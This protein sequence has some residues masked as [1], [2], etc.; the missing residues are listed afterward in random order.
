[1]RVLIVDD[2]PGVRQ[3]VAMTLAA[4]HVD[5]H[6]A[7]DGKAALAE[8]AEIAHPVDAIVLDLEMPV[9]DG[10][11]FVRELRKQQFTT[12]VVLLSAYATESARK[13]LGAAAAIP[14]PFDPFVLAEKVKQVL[15]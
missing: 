8:I 11:T 9:M 15:E 10:W 14:K 3:L 6:M 4:E 5:V 7:G 1:M 13:E 2:D 12:P